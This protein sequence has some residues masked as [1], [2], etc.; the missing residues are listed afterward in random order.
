VAR[1]QFPVEVLTPEGMV[2]EGEVE[3]VSTRTSVGSIGVLANHAPLM[4]I[5]EP[6]ELRLY[7]SGSENPDSG[8][9]EVFAQG[10][11][12]IQV[13]DNSALLIVEEATP[14]DQLDRAN[15]ETKL[16]E[17]QDRLERAQK[18]APEEGWTPKALASPEHR[19]ES[20]ELRRA[21]SAVKRYET[22]LE[23]AG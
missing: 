3:M 6:A 4:A 7:K 17:A 1:S 14:P 13:I 9:A 15:L 23:I 2:F 5:L 20:E 18:D 16:K 19:A 12:Y 21:E 22:F 10:E 8:D 11:G